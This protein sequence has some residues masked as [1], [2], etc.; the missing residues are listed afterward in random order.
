MDTSGGTTQPSTGALQASRREF[1]RGEQPKFVRHYRLEKAARIVNRIAGSAPCDLLDVGCGPGTL[2]DFLRGNIR[3]FG[4]DM[5]I[6]SPRSNFR[7]MDFLVS[8]IA[9]DGKQFDVVVA[10]GVFEYLADVSAQK[11]AEIRALLKDTGHFVV[12]YT[13]FG[14]R[15]PQISPMFSNVVP[16][17]QFRN[18]LETHFHISKAFPTSYNWSHGQPSRWWMRAAQKAV[19]LDVP[20]VGTKLGVEYFF[21]CSPRSERGG[22]DPAKSQGAGRDPP[23]DP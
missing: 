15:K 20:L 14:H 7:E 16:I 6:A 22:L 2:G 8:P 18:S 1:W 5:A 3:Y 23:S 21:I 17:T 9:F 12:C 13:N 19:D 10:L 4:L 11:L